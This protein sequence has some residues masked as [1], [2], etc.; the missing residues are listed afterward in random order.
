MAEAPKK[1]WQ[2]KRKP[3]WRDIY[4]KSR[5]QPTWKKLRKRQSWRSSK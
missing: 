1:G 3:K 5:I 4:V 2:K